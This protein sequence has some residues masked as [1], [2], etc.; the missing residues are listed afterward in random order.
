MILFSL[1][2]L[3][4]LVFTLETWEIED[5]IEDEVVQAILDDWTNE[6]D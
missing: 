4:R 1:N 6:Q 2:V 3:G 5:A